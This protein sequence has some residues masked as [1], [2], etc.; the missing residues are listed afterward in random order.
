[1]PYVSWISDADLERELQVIMSAAKAAKRDAESKFEKNVIDPFAL[2]FE[3]YGFGID[4][5]NDWKS[6]EL[7]RQVQKSLSNKFGTF[8]QGILGSIDGWE[9]LGT[10]STVDLVNYEKKVIAEV[11]N[12]Y[13]T[14]KGDYKSAL[15]ETLEGLITPKASKYHGFTA[16]Y[17]EIIP[18]PVRRQPQ[19]FDKPFIPS[20]NKKGALKPA[21]PKIRVIDG[22]SFYELATGESSALLDLFESVPKVLDSMYGNSPAMV[23]DTDPM[24]ANALRHM[25]YYFQRAWKRSDN[26]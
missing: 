13:N 8:H 16:Y 6:R 25:K 18:K 21:N 14:T 10:G 9:D 20:D 22:Q 26:G 3:M 2:I 1:M 15:Y 19:S 11:K 4:D 23:R 5:F 7:D 17:V 24:S 12:K